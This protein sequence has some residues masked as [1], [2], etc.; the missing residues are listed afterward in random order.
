MTENLRHSE[1]RAVLQ[2]LESEYCTPAIA[3]ARQRQDEILTER[4]VGRVADSTIADIGCGTGYHGSLFA[5]QCRLYH[6]YEI[7]EQIAQ[8][9][10]DRWR[11]QGL[12]NIE[13]FL[14]DVSRASPPENYYDLAW[15]LYFTPGNFRDPADD[16]SRYTDEYLDRNPNFIA[17]F[18]RFY[19]ALKPGGRLFLTVYKDV[20][21]AEAAQFDF[22]AKT[23]QHVVTPPGSRFVATAEHFWS[24]RWSKDSLLSNLGACGIAA[25]Q[26]GWTDLNEIAWLVEVT[27]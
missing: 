21:E 3:E 8:I 19:R 26:I 27:R 23:G 11:E 13:L 1:A 25:G 10:Q 5:P 18:S 6:G 4:F 12:G 22:Y 24:A 16:L 20:P 17:V 15:C 7:S 2:S 14:G 9:A